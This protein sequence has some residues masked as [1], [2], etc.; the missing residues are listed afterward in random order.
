MYLHC[1]YI[2]LQTY[3]L[4]IFYMIFFV[5]P[6][7]A[8]S[9]FTNRQSA[10]RVINIRKILIIQIV[11]IENTGSENKYLHNFLFTSAYYNTTN[12]TSGLLYP[13]QIRPGITH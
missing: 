5:V 11:T 2:L 8:E 12:R 13:L 6:R 1:V 10:N 3:K 4:S 7:F 9:R